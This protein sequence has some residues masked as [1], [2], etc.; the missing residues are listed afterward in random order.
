MRNISFNFMQEIVN[1]IKE[2][3]GNNLNIVQISPHKFANKE[4]KYLDNC[5]VFKD[6]FTYREAL[7]FGKH[8]ILA[9]VPHGG[10]SIGLATVNTK[11]IAIYP[12]IHK[13]QMTTYKSEIAYEISDGTHYSCYLSKCSICEK[14][15]N[16]FNKNQFENIIETVKSM[17]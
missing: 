8:A 15:Q 3:Y 14:L 4:S 6:Y 16:N 13:V 17:V 5:I 7:L 9:I 2:L 1:K 12:C 10:L 11:V